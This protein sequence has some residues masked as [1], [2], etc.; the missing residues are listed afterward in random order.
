MALSTDLIR[1]AVGAGQFG[2]PRAEAF[3]VRALSERRDAIGR[4]YLTAVNPLTKPTI[5]ASGTLTMENAAV[6]ADLAHAPRGYRATWHVFDNATG[7]TRCFGETSNELSSLPAP[8]GLP[9]G[10]GSF[11]KVEVNSID[12]PYSVWESPVSVYFRLQ[13]GSW[14]LVGLERMGSNE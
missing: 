12:A 2:D 4:A 14:R 9:H 1:A 5:D 8:A 13:N 3:L 6:E 7:K 10:D 11:V